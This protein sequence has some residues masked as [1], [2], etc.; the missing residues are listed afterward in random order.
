MPPMDSLSINPLTYDLDF[1]LAT[2]LDSVRQRVIQAIRLAQ[3]DWFLVPQ[4]GVP[5]IPDI[6][7]SPGED[8]LISRL[9]ETAIRSVPDVTDIRDIALSFNAR[10]RRY[11]FSAVIVATSGT[12]TLEDTL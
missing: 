3:G 6:L 8:D 9:I 10:T 5:Y 4:R 11:R 7:G 2:G 1:T 12:T